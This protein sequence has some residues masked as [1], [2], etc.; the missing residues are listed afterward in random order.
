MGNICEKNKIMMFEYNDFCPLRIVTLNADIDESINK[1]SKIDSIIEYFMKPYNGYYIDVMCIQGIRNVRII[2]EIVSSFKHRIEK[3]NDDIRISFGKSIYLEYFPDITVSDKNDN[4]I[5]WST[6]ESGDNITYYDKL[7]ISRHSI[8]QSAD[9]PICGN[10]SDIFHK[11]DIKLMTNTIDS[12]DIS[13]M[14]KYIQIVNLN[15]D[16]TFVSIYNIELGYDSIGISNTKER[17]QQIHDIKNIIDANRIH[18]L[19][20]ETRQF[21]YGDNTFISCNRDIHIVTGIFHINEIKNSTLSSEYIRLCT[22]LNCLDMHRWIASLRKDTQFYESNVR[23][24]K[25]TYT[26]LISKN[27]TTHPDSMSRS[28]KL[29]EVHKCV[30]INSTIPKHIVDMN[31]FS[32]YPEDTIIMM[33]RPNI[34]L[35]NNKCLN[36]VSKNKTIKQPFNNT[37]KFIDQV[38]SRI[39]SESLSSNVHPKYGMKVDTNTSNIKGNQIRYSHKQENLNSSSNSI[40]LVRA[41]SNSN[42]KSLDMEHSKNLSPLKI[43]IIEDQHDNDSVESIKSA[44]LTQEYK[45][46]L[47]NNK[48]IMN[49][50][51]D[52]DNADTIDTEQKVVHDLNKDFSDDEVNAEIECILEHQ[53][54]I[55]K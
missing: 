4:D 13:N 1:K 23:F 26:M 8:L 17:R 24:T 34:E 39:V 47:E 14:Y 18:S 29:F 33:Y 43:N 11:N 7:I 54:S 38:K 55:T 12:D 31:Q 15:V 9:V 51:K 46:T 25:D 20:E 35:F 53:K 41:L 52:I 42:D 19:N 28:Q 27:V 45:N 21:I 30:I 32:N 50:S 48:P 37:S 44:D 6:S 10:K 3:Y 49:V 16:G 22:S 5:Y 40:I 36:I 2:K